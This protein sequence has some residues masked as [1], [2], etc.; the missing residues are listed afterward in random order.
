MSIM[1]IFFYF[2]LS[3]QDDD[4]N[5]DEIAEIEDDKTSIKI[6]LVQDE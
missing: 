5:Q 3:L 6:E 1:L 2:I 4:M